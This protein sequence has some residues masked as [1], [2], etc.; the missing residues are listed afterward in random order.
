MGPGR[1]G[2]TRVSLIP[3]MLATV[4]PCCTLTRCELASQLLSR[5]RRYAHAHENEQHEFF[6][7]YSLTSMCTVRS[8]LLRVAHAREHAHALHVACGGRVG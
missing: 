2:H 5:A 8:A 1:R 3:C 6:G 4:Q 7:Y